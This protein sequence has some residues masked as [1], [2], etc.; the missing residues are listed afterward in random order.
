M[1]IDEFCLDEKEIH[2]VKKMYKHIISFINSHRET[3][4]INISK[5]SLMYNNFKLWNRQMYKLINLNKE[6]EDMLYDIFYK[7][8]PPFYRKTFTKEQI[9]QKNRKNNKG[10]HHRSGKTNQFEYELK[11]ETIKKLK[12]KF[13]NIISSFDSYSY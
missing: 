2:R 5:Y 8:F 13:K 7:E 3:E 1:T 6:Q 11:E 10:P 12:M 9:I 4:N